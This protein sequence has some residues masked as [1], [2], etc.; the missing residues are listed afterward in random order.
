M[1]VLIP[2]AGNNEYKNNQILPLIEINN[3]TI[4]EY[5]LDNLNFKEKTSFI[6][7]I[8]ESDVNQYFLDSVLKLL[9]PSCK[10][11]TVQ[12]QAQGQ[13]CSCLLGIKYLDM[14][15]SLLIING[16]QYIFENISKIISNFK[17]SNADGGIVT[18]NNI[19]PKW[20]FVR[21]DKDGKTVLET[22]EKRPISR[23]A[24]VGIYY[25][26]KTKNFI[27]SAKD[28]IRKDTLIDGKFYVSSTYNEMILNSNKIIAYEIDKKNF[29]S[30]DSDVT[31]NSFSDKIRRDLK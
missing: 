7:I 23:N 10:I 22:S 20:S 13:L 26:K 19:H 31:I 4:I 11:I 17:K 3:K 28:V 9:K 29:H 18:F 5:V 21:L 6:F 15:D 12:N 8:K 16:D 1:N 24:C 27:E 25:Y 30:L 2:L 14:D